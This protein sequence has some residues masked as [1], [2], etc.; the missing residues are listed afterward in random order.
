MS[1]DVYLGEDL[2]R[3]EGFNLNANAALL[4]ETP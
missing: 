2:G 4:H 3:G 1:N